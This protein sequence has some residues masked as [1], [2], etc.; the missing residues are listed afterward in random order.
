MKRALRIST[1][2]A[3]LVLSGSLFAREI[4]GLPLANQSGKTGSSNKTVEELCQPAR[5]QS[6][7]NI[8][9]V[10]TTI[11]GGGDMWWDLNQARYEV[12][13]GSNRHSMFAG[14][15]WLGGIDDGNQLKLAA[16]TY[17]QRGN[18]FWP[19]PLSNDNLASVTKEVCDKYDRHWIIYREDVDVHK[20][21]LDCKADPNC[22]EAVNFPGYANQIPDIISNWPAFGIDGEQS[23]RLA[24]F[25]DVDGDDDYNPEY[26]YPAYDIDRQFDCRLKETDVLYGDQTIWWVYNDRGNIHTET[27]AGSLGFEIRAQA[28][29]FTTNDEINNMTFNNYRIINK[30]SF[31]LTNTYFSTWFDPDLGFA[32]DDLIGCDIPRGLGYC[33]NGDLDDEGPL[34]YGTNPPAVGFDFFQGPFADYFDGIDN[35]RDG[36]ID[37]VRDSAGNCIPE[38]IAAG[39]NERIIMS[40]F[41]YYSRSGTGSANAFT[42]DPDNAADFYNYM[43]SRWKNGNPLVI[44]NP[45]GPGG[46]ANGDGYTPTGVGTV[47]KFAF[48][49]ETFDTTGVSEPTSAVGGG[50]WF[51]SPSNK[52]DKRG[53]HNAGPFSLAPGALNFITTGVVWA[54]DYNA[55]NIL[56]SVSRVIAADDKAQSLF[57]NC[58]Q[59]LNGPDAPDMTIQELNREVI[60]MLSN[61]LSS[62]NQNLSYQEIDPLIG[63]SDNVYKFEGFQIFQLATA[64][65][66]VA[67]R[68][69]LSQA[70][71]V[72]QC[73]VQNNV[74][75]LINWTVDADLNQLIPQDMTLSE[76]N[77]GVNMSFRI[78]EDAFATGNDRRLVNNRDYYYTV[79]AYAYNNYKQFDVATASDGQK[80]PFL[81]GRR[82][83]TTYKA[84]PRLVGA[85]NNGTIQNAN[86]GDQPLITRVDG[87]GN[88]AV[89]LELTENSENEIVTNASAKRITY[90]RGSGPVRLQVVDPLNVA[91]GTYTMTFNGVSGSSG[92]SITDENNNVVATSDYPLSFA[93]EQLIPELGISVALQNAL[94]PGRDSLGENGRLTS[95]VVYGDPTK[96]WLSGVPDNDAFTPFNW[97]L[98]GTNTN[99]T[100]APANLYKDYPN[101]P[102][103]QFEMFINGTWSPAHY[104]SALG[105]GRASN[106]NVYGMGPFD[107][108]AINL[109]DRINVDQ[110]HSID[111][112]FT[113]DRSKWTRVPVFEMCDDPSLSEGGADKFYLRAQDGWKV[114][115][116]TM[117]RDA[118]NPGWS[119]FPGYAIDVE[120]GQ[121]LNIGFGENSWMVG[122]NGRDMLFNPTSRFVM[123]VAD[124]VTGGYRFGGQ[125]YLYIFGPQARKGAGL[126]PTAF[127]SNDPSQH[128][129]KS[130]LNNMVARANRIQVQRAI[131]WVS[132]VMM[133]AAFD[134]TDLYNNLP[135]ET[136][137][138]LRV[139]RPYESYVAT[140]ENS[141]IP[142]YEFTMDGLATKTNDLSTAQSALDE[143]RVV[144]NPYYAYS[145]Y[146]ESQLDNTVK[147]T[148]LPVDCTVSIFSSNGTLI[149]TIRKSNT[150]TWVV[151][152]LKNNNNVPIASGVY[153]I[154]VN[155]PGIGEKV[156]KWFGALR[157]V[158]LNAF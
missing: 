139:S 141:G 151:W 90:K 15:L 4:P 117:V 138:R 18:D 100:E 21:W 158:D 63:A 64:N 25:I 92:W 28:F 120:T 33:Y 116:G 47:T 11:L 9:N 96:D 133:D 101:D 131:M 105:R 20:A 46:T 147:I 16:M 57:D 108:T 93:G 10:R 38:N 91:T 157:P 13:K 2:G 58:F 112:V 156:I 136:R 19:G 142:K 102:T 154:H 43:Q 143:I 89:P 68:Y 127:V 22:D 12:P 83:I 78:T 146:E 24:P 81:A 124:P 60:I 123:P 8:N 66:S 109:G 26:D 3:I 51:D 56:S 48:M 75:R 87:I 113:S 49:G 17:R 95:L 128:P 85:E 41:M 32:D 39:I 134:G 82:N 34:G 23:Q 144:P 42:D 65:T 76:A 152:D 88:S 129:L 137:V 150:D 79:I 118:A 148:N 80:I 140:N 55:A 135:T 130:E 98:A 45:N 31:R 54:R 110:T 125:H 70:R 114:E 67:D 94:A 104:V 153:I 106:T 14:A 27:S 84:T 97:I 5:A 62:N 86:Y 111:V 40:G 52:A 29:A 119:V 59:V 121:R 1:L 61:G 107:S 145:K 30:S 122:D 37:G 71:L 132:P 115:N 77:E 99:A 50:G 72:A 73:D 103:G 36:C 6:D 126:I 44:E 53:L 155:A 7:L 149:R 69:D 35:D 74:T